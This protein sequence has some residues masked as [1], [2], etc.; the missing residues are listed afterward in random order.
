MARCVIQ[1]VVLEREAF[2]DG[3]LVVEVV[4]WYMHV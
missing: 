2:G 1:I 4:L 3:D